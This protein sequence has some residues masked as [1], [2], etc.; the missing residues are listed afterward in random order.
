MLVH[1]EATELAAALRREAELARER[2]ELREQLEET[3]ARCAILV[4]IWAAVRVGVCNEEAGLARA[5]TLR[6]VH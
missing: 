5:V 1:F 4:G 2:D 3:E 6:Q